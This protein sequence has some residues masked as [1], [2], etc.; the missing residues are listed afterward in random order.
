M[1]EGLILTAYEDTV[2][3]PYRTWIPIPGR[4]HCVIDGTIVYRGKHPHF[5]AARALIKAG[6]DP[7]TP[8]TTT[9]RQGTIVF[10]STLAALARLAVTETGSGPK[11]PTLRRF[12]EMP[13]SVRA[14]TR[15]EPSTE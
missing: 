5:G 4:W 12:A 8:I 3:S 6:H 1:S 7:A 9:T 13:N 10:Q 2:G 15:G 14:V 11:P